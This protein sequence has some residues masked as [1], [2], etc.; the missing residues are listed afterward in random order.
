MP[1]GAV[2]ISTK[3]KFKFS[4]NSSSSST[5][6]MLMPKADELLTPSTHQLKNW[7]PPYQRRTR[8]MLTWPSKL[9]KRHS[10]KARRGEPRIQRTEP[11][12]C[13]SLQTWLKEM[14][15]IWPRWNPW[16]MGKYLGRRW[17]MI[18]L[19]PLIHSDTML[20]GPIKYM[21]KFCRLVATLCHTLAT[22]LLGLQVIPLVRELTLYFPCL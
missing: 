16:T 15:L 6:N 8:R 4:S 11:G 10:V 20:A 13:V 17:M 22:N 5:T 3:T 18:F 21:A 12:S 14:R 9:P 19:W 1:Y 7:S 2:F